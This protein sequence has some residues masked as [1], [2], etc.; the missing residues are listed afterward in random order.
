VLLCSSRSLSRRTLTHKLQYKVCGINP[1][2]VIMF[3]DNLLA[4]YVAAFP[5]PQALHLEH[6]AGAVSRDARAQSL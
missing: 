3:I 2:W 5:K 4:D 6:N 1:Q